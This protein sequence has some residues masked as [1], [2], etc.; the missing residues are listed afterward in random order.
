MKVTNKQ[1]EIIKLIKDQCEFWEKSNDITSFT[2]LS[3]IDECINNA[4][5]FDSNL[6]KQL[7]KDW[8]VS[9]YYIIVKNK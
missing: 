5:C 8:L 7:F 6:D 3:D 2:H 1:K 9:L 4:E